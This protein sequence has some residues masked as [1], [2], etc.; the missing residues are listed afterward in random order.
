MDT[1]IESEDSMVRIR[2]SITTSIS[3]QVIRSRPTSLLSMAPEKEPLI[4]DVNLVGAPPEVEQLVEHIKTVA[5]QFLYHW[6]TFPIC[7]FSRSMH[8]LC[9]S[10]QFNSSRNLLN[11]ILMISVL[12]QPLSG[13]YD[14]GSMLINQQQPSSLQQSI[15]MQNARNKCRPINLRDLF[16]APP[17]DELDAVAMDGIGEPRRLTNSQ[18]KSLRERG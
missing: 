6:K 12:P 14:I 16:I 15:Q 8:I 13:K 18:L 17:F 1:S 11:K 3:S 4:F 7:K 10:I 9:I 2:P 5:E